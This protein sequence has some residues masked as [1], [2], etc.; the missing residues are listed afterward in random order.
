MPE[1]EE[2]LAR[3]LDLEEINCQ[4]QKLRSLRRVFYRKDGDVAESDSPEAWSE[5]A[6]DT[7]AEIM[8][9]AICKRNPQPEKRN[10]ETARDT[11]G[12]GSLYG[13][14]LWLQE[15]IHAWTEADAKKAFGENYGHTVNHS[16]NNKSAIDSDQYD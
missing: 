8:F 5:P 7:N 3:V 2:T 1:D 12:V 9:R 15:R 16:D 6:P 13:L 10:A 4:S 11:G 14:G